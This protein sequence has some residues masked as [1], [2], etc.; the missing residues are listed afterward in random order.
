[1][2]Y[3][4]WA[5][6]FYWA[7]REP[8]RAGAAI[9]TIALVNGSLLVWAARRLQ[10]LSLV[11]ER[12]SRLADGLALL[13]DT[14]E[15]GLSTLIKEVEQLGGRRKASTKP[16]SRSSVAKRVTSAV[17][18]GEKVAEIATTEGLSESEVR[19]HLSMAKAAN[20]KATETTAA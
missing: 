6:D 20:A 4:L 19:L 15:A 10:E 12:V 3:L 13:T 16:S 17:E 8:F 14:T 11:R 5:K 18:K 7:H 2:D 1:M 9:T